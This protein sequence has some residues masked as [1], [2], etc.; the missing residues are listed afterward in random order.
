MQRQIPPPPP[1]KAGSQNGN[2]LHQRVRD[3]CMLLPAFFRNAVLDI[4]GDDGTGVAEV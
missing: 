3:L 1:E 2:T 4:G